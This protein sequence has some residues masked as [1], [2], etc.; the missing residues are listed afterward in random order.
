MKTKYLFFL[1]AVAASLMISCQKDEDELFVQYMPRGEKVVVISDIHLNDDRAYQQGYA[2]ISSNGKAELVSFLDSIAGDASVGTLVVNGDVFDEWCSPMDVDP[3][4]DLS[5]RKTNSESEYF[6]VLVRDN[7]TVVDAFRR[8]KDAGVKLVYVPG[9]H[10]MLVSSSDIE[11][12]LNGLFEQAR[13]ADG[14]GS[15][16][17][18]GMDEVVIE[19]GHRYDYSNAPELL[20]PTGTMCPIGFPITKYIC[21]VDLDSRRRGQD[22][23]SESGFSLLSLIDTENEY[24]RYVWDSIMNV[25]GL[26]DS[27]GHATLVDFGNYYSSVIVHVIE[28]LAGTFSGEGDLFNYWCFQTVWGMILMNSHYP[29]DY[30][31]IEALLSTIKMTYGEYVFLKFIPLKENFTTPYDGVW[32]QSHW[33]ERCRTNRVSEKLPFIQSVLAGALDNS[34]EDIVATQYFNNQQSNKRIVVLGHTHNAKLECKTNNNGQS[35]IYANSGTWID[36][37]FA[38]KNNPT[39]SFVEIE[40]SDSQYIIRLKQFHNSKTL[41]T[42]I[43]D[44]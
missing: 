12:V 17:P 34:I 13:D 25:R 9:N 3:F 19:H 6:K 30:S 31:N 35:C 11:S 40:R 42:Q 24:N 7:Q 5:G 4:V 22:Y 38:G 10:D 21:S 29:D 8:L 37:F 43:L 44:L 33:E 16:T 2:W 14:L 32:S 28:Y 39:H 26:N 36:P 27:L 41:K 15:Y 20:S 23:A 1:L 18:E